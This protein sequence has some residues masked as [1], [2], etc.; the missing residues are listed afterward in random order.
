VF[1]WARCSTFGTA[2]PLGYYN[3]DFL[4]KF[5][6]KKYTN[7]QAKVLPGSG[8]TYVVPDQYY[9]SGKSDTTLLSFNPYKEHPNWNNL[10]IDINHV[11]TSRP[12]VTANIL[13]NRMDELSTSAFHL[14]MALA[15]FYY[16]KRTFIVVRSLTTNPNRP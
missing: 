11:L 13:I 15:G 5:K 1:L 8:R 12:Q 14:R 4:L 3:L 2:P 9:K 10:C 16:P 6:S 7:S